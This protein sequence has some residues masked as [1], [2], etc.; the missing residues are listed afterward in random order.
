MTHDE[1]VDCLC[2]GHWAKYPKGTV[3][4]SRGQPP[5]GLRVLLSGEAE[6]R[7]G[8]AILTS[9]EVGDVRGDIVRPRATSY[10]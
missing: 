1:R 5:D 6:V 2:Y 9:L 3:L 7:L 10:G 4:M 8:P